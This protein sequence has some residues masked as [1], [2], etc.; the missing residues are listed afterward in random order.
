MDKLH[1]FLDI[2]DRQLDHFI[3]PFR[4]TMVIFMFSVLAYLH[5]IHRGVEET[6]KIRMEEKKTLDKRIL[7]PCR[8]KEVSDTPRITRSRAKIQA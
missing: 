2:A 5:C 1:E 8:H 7:C 3:F 6:N 4:C